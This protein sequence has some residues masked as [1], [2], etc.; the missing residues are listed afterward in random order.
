MLAQFLP[1]A[2]LAASP[3]YPHKHSTLRYQRWHGWY[4]HWPR[5]HASLH[6]LPAEASVLTVSFCCL[7]VVE[8]AP[9]ILLRSV[10]VPRSFLL[11]RFPLLV[12][13]AALSTA[14]GDY[15]VV[16]ISHSSVF[17]DTSTY[18]GLGWAVLPPLGLLLPGVSFR[19]YE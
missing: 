5:C 17:H 11:C 18:L 13:L 9:A 1:W 3:V 12:G 7:A 19:E 10:L 16:Y 8:L 6:E 4:R 2:A 14:V 15:M